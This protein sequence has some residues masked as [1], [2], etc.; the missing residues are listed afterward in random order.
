MKPAPQR[1]S[2][3]VN[4]AGRPAV[5]SDGHADRD[6]R[7]GPPVYDYRG[8]HSL[9]PSPSL[10]PSILPSESL[11]SPRPSHLKFRGISEHSPPRVFSESTPV[12]HSLSSLSPSPLLSESTPV[13]V[14]S[15]G[16]IPCTRGGACM[17]AHARGCV[18]ARARVCLRASACLRSRVCVRV[19]LRVCVGWWMGRLGLSP[20]LWESGLVD[21]PPCV[22]VVRACEGPCACARAC[23]SKDGSARE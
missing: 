15:I 5:A 23:G 1:P 16:Y 4:R 22:R 12:P 8:A 21:G 18:R 13:R 9:T 3:E 6:R 7:A 10:H 19:S 2:P 14:L 20:S 17:C 11:V